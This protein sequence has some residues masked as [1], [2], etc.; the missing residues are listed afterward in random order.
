[1]FA[2]LYTSVVPSLQLKA[3]SLVLFI[4][5]MPAHVIIFSLGHKACHE[6]PIEWILVVLKVMPQCMFIA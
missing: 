1:M 5:S 3:K 4:W 6:M 2:D